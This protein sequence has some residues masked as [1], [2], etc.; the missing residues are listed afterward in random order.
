MCKSA[1]ILVPVLTAIAAT[2]APRDVLAAAV[3]VPA[4]P[5]VAPV[6]MVTETYFGVTVPDPYRYMENLEDPQVE[7]WFRFAFPAKPR[8]ARRAGNRSKWGGAQY[9][10]ALSA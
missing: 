4:T 10:T 7:A 8:L 5:P 9:E 1:S 2:A 6:K 3:S